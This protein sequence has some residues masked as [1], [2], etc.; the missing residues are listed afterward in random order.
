MFNKPLVNHSAL[1]VQVLMCRLGQ[2]VGLNNYDISYNYFYSKVM[3][4]NKIRPARVGSRQR[5]LV[6]M[7]QNVNTTQETTER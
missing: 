6:R 4:Q 3:K 5:A 2:I 1:H 7:I